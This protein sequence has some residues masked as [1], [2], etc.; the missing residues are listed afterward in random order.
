M[1][2]VLLLLLLLQAQDVGA[3][4][5]KAIADAKLKEAK[6]GV[7]I[8]SPAGAVLHQ[9]GE[10]DL[11]TLASNSKLLTTSCALAKLGPD[12]KFKTTAGLVGSELHVFGGGDPNISG[13]FFDDDPSALF[14]GWAKKLGEMKVAKLDAIVLHPALFDRTYVHPDWGKYDLDQWWAAPVGAL[15]LNDNCVDL[16]YEAGEAEGDPVRITVRPATAYVTLTNKATTVKSKP[17]PFGFVRKDGT[18]EIT[19]N[20]ELQ[21][22]TKQRV[23]WVAIQ[24]PTQFFGTVLKE[25]L[26]AAGIATGEVKEADTLLEEYK[27]LKPVAVHETDLAKTVRVCNTVSQNFYAEMICKTLGAKFK[28]AGTAAAGS[29]V[30]VEWLKTV[31]IEDAAMTDGCGLSP[32][33]K[34]SAGGIA[35]L[36]QWWTKQKDFKIFRDSLAVSGGEGT[37][38]RRMAA[39]KGKV[40]AKTGHIDGVSSLSGYVE[41]EGGEMVFSLLVNGW[42][43]GS[44]DKF[45]DLVCEALAKIK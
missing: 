35:K 26:A 45:Q 4:V 38:K 7:V 22:G 19:A 17:K 11:L 42:K 23:A 39:V 21:V 15:S 18:N 10:T 41:T 12:F 33:N 3:L 5:D 31:G 25:T 43:G 36:L 28:G 14:K 13:R 16:L 6:L 8:L 34:C 40:R 30:V 27:E 37:L 2:R 44:A 9:R 29:S 32:K 1:R 20:G 24:D